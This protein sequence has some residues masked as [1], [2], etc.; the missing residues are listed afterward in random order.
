MLR[1]TGLLMVLLIALAAG[2][3]SAQQ[4]QPARLLQQDGLVLFPRPLPVS[5]FAFVDE[6]GATAARSD[7]QGRWQLLFFGYTYC[8]DI[9][10]MTLTHLNRSWQRLTPGQQ[11]QLGV[12][13]VSV[14]PQRDTPESLHLYMDYFNPEF[15][16]L[17]GNQAALQTLAT[18]LHAVYNRVE[19][20]DG[21]AYL[22]D[23]S[24]NLAILDPQGRYRG[25]ISPPHDPE[26]LVPLLKLLLDGAAG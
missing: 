11:Q 10:P 15:R 20:P 24:A 13:M 3:L 14:D 25:Y 8:P 4:N 19:R 5:D 16:A 6:H 12:A 1:V 17:T 18:E 2:L 23:H 7:L 26:R 21:Q 22:M 9:C